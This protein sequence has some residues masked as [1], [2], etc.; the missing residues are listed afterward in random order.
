VRIIGKAA[1]LFLSFCYIAIL[2]VEPLDV[3]AANVPPSAPKNYFNDFAGVTRPGTGSELER[4]LEQFERTQSVQIVV[5][6]FSKLPEGEALEDFTQRTAAAWKV[7]RKA[8]NNGVVFFAF[9]QDRKMRI[10]VGYGLEGKI[11][12]A[13]ARRITSEQIKPHFQRGDYDAGIR[14][15]TRA[16]MQAAAG[17]YKGT[18][19]TI[20]ESLSL[21]SIPWPI[22]IFGVLFA[23]IA[24]SSF[25]RRRGTTYSRRGRADPGWWPMWTGGNW[26]GGGWSGGG[27]S[28]GGF[29][30]G[31]GDF[32][33]GG[34][35]DSW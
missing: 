15:G 34:A 19:K 16:L 17:E 33:G 22:I 8:S 20:G 31:G 21:R 6:I 26:G 35:S 1:V 11:P 9:I 27:G 5:A 23:A 25:R 28:G 13:I 32:G 14:A 4:Q 2:L 3:R 24:L 12:D 29:S 10:E 7:G 18:G 30:A